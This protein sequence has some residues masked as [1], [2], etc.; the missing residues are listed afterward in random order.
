MQFAGKPLGS[1]RRNWGERRGERRTISEGL[2]WPK[3]T[4]PWARLTHLDSRPVS[5]AD[6]GKRP[7]S[8]ER[9]WRG[10][11]EGGFEPPDGPK[12][13]YRFSRPVRSSPATSQC[14]SHEL[15]EALSAALA[16]DD[17]AA[18]GCS[19]I[20]PA[21]DLRLPGERSEAIPD[22]RLERVAQLVAPGPALDVDHLVPS[23]R[24]TTMRSTLRRG[25]RG[26]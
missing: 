12:G 17:D 1:Q 15:L 19:S 4:R 21:G 6:D 25:R 24:S 3:V 14:R 13:R 16:L 7:T 11:G 22:R 8:A 23:S 18:I 20:R 2:R 10:G 26:R 9:G 5:P